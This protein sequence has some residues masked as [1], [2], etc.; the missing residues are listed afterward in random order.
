MHTLRLKKDKANNQQPLKSKSKLGGDKT[1]KH[2]QNN[3]LKKSNAH[4]N[5]HLKTKIKR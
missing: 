2:S 3:K 4:N 5:P 1:S